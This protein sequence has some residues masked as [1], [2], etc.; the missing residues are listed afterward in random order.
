MMLDTI[1]AIQPKESSQSS[2]ETRE[3]VVMRLAKEM[4]EKVPPNYDPFMVK[5]R[6]GLIS[7]NRLLFIIVCYSLSSSDKYF[8]CH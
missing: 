8:L 3:D 5:D 2:G 6:Y 7:Q 1:L 4:I